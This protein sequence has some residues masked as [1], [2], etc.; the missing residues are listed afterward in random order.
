MTETPA[1][2]VWSA[3]DPHLMWLETRQD[4]NAQRIRCLTCGPL[5]A[6]DEVEARQGA[7]GMDRV[8]HRAHVARAAAQ[9]ADS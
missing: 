5:Y 7:L 6:R 9:A 2:D 4:G 8:R 3:E 1:A